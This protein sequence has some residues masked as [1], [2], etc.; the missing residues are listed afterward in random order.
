MVNKREEATDSTDLDFELSYAGIGSFLKAPVCEPDDLATDGDVDVAALGVP[1]DGGVSKDPGARFGPSSIRD[2]SA[3][4]ATLTDRDEY[5]NT[6]TS[7]KVTLGDVVFRDV[8]DVP[9]FPTDIERTHDAIE[10]AVQ[11]IAMETFPVVLGGDHSLTYPSAVGFAK[12]RD[13]R[14]GLVHIDAHT[15]I[16]ESSERFGDRFHGSPMARLA[17]TE[18]GGYENH[19]IIGLRKYARPSFENRIED[20]GL[21]VA[22]IRDVRENGIETCV[23]WAIEHASDGVDTVYLTVDIDSVDPGFAPGTGTPEPGGLTSDELLRAMTQLGTHDAIGAM[24]LVEVAP[25][26]DPTNVTQKLAANAIVRFLETR[27]S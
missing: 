1:F 7:R 18:Y 9:V 25:K 19:A 24:D 23:K 21:S 6:A 26:L 16:I 3:W 17:E 20:D 2:A 4:Y 12:A 14:I 22:T 13:E 10:G 15:D 5:L 11:T 27:F 8:G